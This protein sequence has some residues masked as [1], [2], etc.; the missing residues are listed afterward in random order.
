[1]KLVLIKKIVL[2]FGTEEHKSVLFVHFLMFNEAQRWHECN[3][4]HR[5]MWTFI[6]KYTFAF[7]D[8]QRLS[9]YFILNYFR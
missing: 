9:C 1:M 3:Y 4:I 6:F 8:A 7:S 2:S 5:F